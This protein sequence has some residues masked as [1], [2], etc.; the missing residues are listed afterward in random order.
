[1]PTI[2]INDVDIYYED[3]APHDEHKP[4]MSTSL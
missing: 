4:V 2:K 3:S 1:M